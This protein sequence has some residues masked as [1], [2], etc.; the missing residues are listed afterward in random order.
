[1]R[2]R[3]GAS[4]ARRLDGPAPDLIHAFG[5]DVAGLAVELAERWKRTYLLSI[6][7][8]LPI[9]SV[10][11]LARRRCRGVVVGGRELGQDMT[12]GLG[13]PARWAHV[14]PP[15]IDL[16]EA[17]AR[18]SQT[19]TRV[20]GTAV[21]SELGSG[22]PAF[23]E[24]ARLVVE[25]GIEAEFVLAGP[26]VGSESARRLA[27]GMGVADR[28]TV[29]D[30]D[31]G[32]LPILNV[33][34]HASRV[35]SLGLP[36]LRAMASGIPTIASDVAGLREASGDGLRSRVVPP[37][38]PEALASAMLDLISDDGQARALITAGRE[39]IR[40][41]YSPDREADE[42]AALYRATIDAGSSSSTRF[43]VDGRARR[44]D[45]SFSANLRS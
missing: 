12:E 17:P 7:D 24:A 14:I 42:L 44:S 38:D 32:F 33:Y 19:G 4:I 26:G 9:G 37:N 13:L 28:V 41:A 15:G 20:I 3:E 39:R 11:R 18:E 30:L 21:G 27:E 10:L 23:L 6:P 2:F 25:R 31:G 22:L 29:A 45:L 35:P 36:L 5:L 40:V 1:M 34:V 8:F 16:V 43:R